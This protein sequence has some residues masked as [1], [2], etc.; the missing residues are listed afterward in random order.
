MQFHEFTNGDLTL[1]FCL[2]LIFIDVISGVTNAIFNRELSS[3]KMREGG[4]H[5]AA[6]IIVLCLGAI[7]AYGGVYIGLDSAFCA[8]IEIAIGSYIGFMELISILENVC[9][10][11]P[12]L[13]ISRLFSIFGVE[14]EKE[15]GK[16]G[17]REA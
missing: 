8:C 5:K 9:L 11:N 7:M 12:E 17:S 2:I 4:K 6:L 3:Q 16:D 15:G 14:D 10:M 1:L 13:K